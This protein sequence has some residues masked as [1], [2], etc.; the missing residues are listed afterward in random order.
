MKGIRYMNNNQINLYKAASRV[1]TDLIVFPILGALLIFINNITIKSFDYHPLLDVNTWFGSFATTYFVYMLFDIIIS[2]VSFMKRHKY[3]FIGLSFITST[4]LSGCIN[5]KIDTNFDRIRS[6]IPIMI[7]D[8]ILLVVCIIIGLKLGISK[9]KNKISKEIENYKKSIKSMSYNERQ[10]FINA[11]N[12]ALAVDELTF[13]II[14]SSD[15]KAA[16]IGL[17]DDLKEIK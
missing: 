3:I 6:Y 13:M 7:V 11:C 9:E 14:N 4:I 12:K 17:L 5:Y 10:R 15:D 2:R 8:V 1:N 16:I